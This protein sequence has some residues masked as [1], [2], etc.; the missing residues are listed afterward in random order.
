VVELIRKKQAQVP[1]RKETGKAA[2]PRNLINLMDALKQSIASA[3]K[4]P[5][6]AA[7]ASRAKSTKKRA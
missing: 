1:A 2:V 4:K 5:K 3:E 6:A 7:A